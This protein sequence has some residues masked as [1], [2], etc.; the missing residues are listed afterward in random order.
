MRLFL[1]GVMAVL[2]L[3]TMFIGCIKTD[4][5]CDGCVEKDTSNNNNDTIINKDTVITG[6]HLAGPLTIAV[7]MNTPAGM[8]AAGA[9]VK[10]AYTF[11]S[12]NQEKYFISRYTDENGY[13]VFND[14]PVDAVTRKKNY[15]ANAYYTYLREEMSSLNGNGSNGPLSITLREGISTSR[16]IIV[17]NR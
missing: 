11:D 8:F 9:E 15:Y 12:V 1:L 13:V 4:L 16:N 17:T 2:A 7:R 6:N 14:L 5:N 3:E 10:L